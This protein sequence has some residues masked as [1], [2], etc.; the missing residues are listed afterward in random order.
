VG[1]RRWSPT[2]APSRDKCNR[3]RDTDELL[4]R[5]GRRLADL[6]AGSR[7]SLVICVGI[8]AATL[9]ARGA[10]GRGRVARRLGEHVALGLELFIGITVL[11]LI[12]NP[13]WA[14]V[15]T[16]TLTIVVRKLVTLSLG[17][18]AGEGGGAA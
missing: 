6:L 4:P 11:N 8:A 12:L 14:A 3:S 16:T 10:G 1:R 5:S 13:T 17:F 15:A 7:G 2:S 18:S 9:E